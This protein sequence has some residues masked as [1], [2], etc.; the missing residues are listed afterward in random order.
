MEN[1]TDPEIHFYQNIDMICEYYSEDEFSSIMKL[2]GFSVIHFNNRSLY[3]NLSKIK[4]YLQQIQQMFSK[5]A[6]SETWL[7]D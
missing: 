6:I 7:S 2:E 4:D 5:I 3:S 1:D